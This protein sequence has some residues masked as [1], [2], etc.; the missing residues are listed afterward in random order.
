MGKED[1]SDIKQKAENLWIP[2][3]EGK[4]GRN[5]KGTRLKKFSPVLKLIFFGFYIFI[6]MTPTLR[7]NFYS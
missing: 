6:L 1:K 4:S 3:I 7:M 5:N 2:L